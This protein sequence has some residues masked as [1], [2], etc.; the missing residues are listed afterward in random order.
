MS[1]YQESDRQ[2]ADRDR[3]SLFRFYFS[4]PGVIKDRYSIDTN[5]EST[6]ISQESI[7]RTQ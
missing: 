4:L 3:L 2:T 6:D 5:Q 1:F 7:G